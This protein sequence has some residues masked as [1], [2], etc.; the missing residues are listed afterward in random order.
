MSGRDP[1]ERHWVATPL[2]L[3]FDLTFMVAFGIAAWEFAHML[4]EDHVGAG[5]WPSRSPRSPSGGL[6]R[7]ENE[8]EGQSAPQ[9]PSTSEWHTPHQNW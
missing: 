2:E 9:R 4:A 8:I 6:A 7:E 3:L 1:H 5:F